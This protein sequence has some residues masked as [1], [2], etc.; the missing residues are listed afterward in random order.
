[1]SEED[2]YPV[3]DLKKIAIRY[4]KYLSSLN[5]LYRSS[6]IFDL[7]TVI[8]FRYMTQSTRAQQ[9]LQLFQLLRLPGLFMIIEPKN[10]SNIVK[11]YYERDIKQVLASETYKQQ[12]MTDHNKIMKQIMVGYVFRIIRLVVIVLLISY[13]S[14]TLWYLF[15]Y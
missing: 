14:G 8:P 13:F 3:R 4:M 11:A 1:M 2:Y 9:L 5:V 12:P 15:C 6:F 10:F 7:L